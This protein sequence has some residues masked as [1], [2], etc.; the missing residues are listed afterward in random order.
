ME[1]ANHRT[2]TLAIHVGPTLT[3]Q[4]EGIAPDLRP[5]VPVQ[6]KASGGKPPYAF[7]YAWKGNRTRGSVTPSG[8]YVPGTVVG[9]VD[10]VEVVDAVRVPVVATG[11][12]AD[13]RTAAEPGWADIY[14]AFLRPSDAA[15]GA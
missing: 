12:I 4:Y 9:A 5:G 6:L 1:D 14:G 2:A 13:A 15:R 8:A 7:R 3:L 10:V 11:G